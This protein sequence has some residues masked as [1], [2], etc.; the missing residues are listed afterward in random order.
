MRAQR[1]IMIKEPD[2]TGRTTTI[3]TNFSHRHDGIKVLSTSSKSYPLVQIPSDKEEDRSPTSLQ[4][5]FR[6]NG[7]TS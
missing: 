5:L 7:P 1:F 3:T 6:S 4:L 2:Y